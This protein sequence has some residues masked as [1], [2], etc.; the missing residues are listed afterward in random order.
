MFDDLVAA[1]DQ[2]GYE[3]EEVVRLGRTLG[4]LD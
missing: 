4:D 1:V 2:A 3:L